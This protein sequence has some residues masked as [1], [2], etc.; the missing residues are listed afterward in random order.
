MAHGGPQE[1]TIRIRTKSVM[2]ENNE[3]IILARLDLFKMTTSP[4][5]GTELS[6][7]STFMCRGRHKKEFKNPAMF[8][9]PFRH[10]TV[11]LL[12]LDSESYN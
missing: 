12:T 2:D 1:L 10:R 11:R 8:G 3:T 6:P 4:S 9:S 7:A 5:H